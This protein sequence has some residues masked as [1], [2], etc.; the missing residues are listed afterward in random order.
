MCKG[1][2]EEGW[3]PIRSHLDEETVW[4]IYKSKDTAKELAHRYGCGLTTIYNIKNRKIYRDIL[5]YYIIKESKAQEGNALRKK[6]TGDYH[7]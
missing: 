3:K 2:P 1:I 5:A 7:G 4:E 6:E